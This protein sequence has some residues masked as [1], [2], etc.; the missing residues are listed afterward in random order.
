[1]GGVDLLATIMLAPKD[2][3][4]EL[5][6][7][8]DGSRVAV[9]G[10]SLAPTPLSFAGFGGST[11]LTPTTVILPYDGFRDTLRIASSTLFAST[12]TTLTHG[13]VP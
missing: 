11:C 4:K 3:M 5:F 13:A 10:L 9:V 7:I 12:V 8:I 6:A 1:M 2:G